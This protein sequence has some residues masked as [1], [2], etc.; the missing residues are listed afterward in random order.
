MADK[1]T[2][3]SGFRVLLS[4]LSNSIYS[5]AV[6]A[7]G[8]TSISGIVTS[9]SNIIS[10]NFDNSVG[11]SYSADDVISD[12]TYMTFNTVSADNGAGVM[13]AGAKLEVDL[14]SVPSGMGGYSLYLFPTTPTTSVLTDNSAFDVG[15]AEFTSKFDFSTPV[16][17]GSKLVVIANEVNEYIKLDDSDN[18]LYG[19]LKSK[20]ACTISSSTTIKVSLKAVII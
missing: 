20:S 11:G 17:E 4:E 6:T 8:T 7:Q 12:N 1:N 2:K 3:I 18:K 14:S 16:D 19:I 5:M 13:I 10:D 15:T 9:E